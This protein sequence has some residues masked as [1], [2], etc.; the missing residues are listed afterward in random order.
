MTWL[1]DLGESRPIDVEP[2]E[3]LGRAA[4]QRGHD[5]AFKPAPDLAGPQRRGQVQVVVGGVGSAGGHRRVVEERAA[6]PVAAVDAHW[7]DDGTTEH[8][9]RYDVSC[10]V[11]CRDQGLHCGR[12]H[13][14][15]NSSEAM[16]RASCGSP[17]PAGQL[18]RDDFSLDPSTKPMEITDRGSSRPGPLKT[19]VGTPKPTSASH[20]RRN[21][22]KVTAAAEETRA[23]LAAGSVSEQV[24]HQRIETVV[25]STELRAIYEVSSEHDFTAEPRSIAVGGTQSLPSALASP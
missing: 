23:W 7:P 14:V 20:S 3:P 17:F 6:A 2:G 22:S 8:N 24:R 13:H 16:V 12:I 9:G 1:D 18:V 11:M 5:F 21:S 10:L 19:L 15:L 25:E 4:G